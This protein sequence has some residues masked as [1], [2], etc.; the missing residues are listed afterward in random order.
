M[1]AG[2]FLA[3]LAL[4]L[5]N[6]LADT[7]VILDFTKPA[8]LAFLAGIAVI[9]ILMAGSFPALYLTRFRPAATLKGEMEEK[10]ISVFQKSLVILQFA[11]SIILLVSVFTIRRQV[12]FVRTADLGFNT[13]NIIS[14]NA[15]GP[16][17]ES[18]DMIKQELERYPEIIEVTAKNS[19]PNEWRHGDAISSTTEDEPFIVEICDIKE[20]YLDMLNIAIV[21]GEPFADYNDSL[22]YVWINEQAAQL[23]GYEDPVDQLVAH[24]TAQ[25]TIKGV[26]SDIKS[27]SLH[28]NI[29]PQ[30]Y[31]KLPRM[32]AQHVVMIK[33]SDDQKAAIA[34]VKEKWNEVNPEYPFE[35]HFLDQAYDDM[36]QNEARAGDIVTWG[37]LIAMFITIIGLFAMARYTT[38]RRTKEIGVRMVNGAELIDILV[39][40]NRNFLKWVVVACLVALPVGWYI[41]KGWL[42][43]FAYRSN[44]SWWILVLSAMTSLLIAIATVSWQSIIAA[45]K[46]PVESLRYE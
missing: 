17:S 6:T 19:L 44:L 30:V 22:N 18:Y 23:L 5:F 40:I 10:N 14:V 39:L 4:P 21:A 32:E 3:K 7:K 34:R 42:E 27:K 37:M 36:Y 41:M 28:N 33:I 15:T 46:N 8:L 31:I 16:F 26:V 35:F 20:N 12:N 13:S 25:F 11:A 1:F 38:E 29:D 45:R 2:I 24:S 9:T 43:S